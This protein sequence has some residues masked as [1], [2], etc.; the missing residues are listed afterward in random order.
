MRVWGYEEISFVYSKS[1][2]TLNIFQKNPIYSK[3][4]Y[5]YIEENFSL[6]KEAI[7]FKKSIIDKEI[8]KK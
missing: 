5:T 2:K 6:L 4:F 3:R 1:L 7:Y 8:R